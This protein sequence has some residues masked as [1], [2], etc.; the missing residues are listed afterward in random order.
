MDRRLIPVLLTA[1]VVGAC[2]AAPAPSDS[3]A[4][5]EELV[6]A[7]ELASLV[8]QP[9]DLPETFFR[10]DEGPL[11]PADAPGGARSDP[12]RFGRLGGW[13]ARYRPAD[14]AELSG[15]LLVE[16]RVD[17]FPTV[18]GAMQDLALYRQDAVSAEPT[19]TSADTDVIGDESA[20]TTLQQSSTVGELRYYT[21][22]WR[23]RNVTA[24]VD[25][26]GLE[27]EISLDHALELARRQQARID[28]AGR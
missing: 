11:S 23:S 4:P 9:A 18:D 5:P 12:N 13:K 3:P 2:S 17:L 10:F 20:V 25:V 27:A 26:Q 16:S 6:P 21:V 28:D 22:T 7:S 14:P 8:L 1:A 15:P 19:A 24:S